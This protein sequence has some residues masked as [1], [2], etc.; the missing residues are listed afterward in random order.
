MSNLLTRRRDALEALA[1]HNLALAHL[2]ATINEPDTLKLASAMESMEF[3]ALDLAACLHELLLLQRNV[4]TLNQ[5]ISDETGIDLSPAAIARDQ[6]LRSLFDTVLETKGKPGEQAARE[7]FA[8]F[9]KREY[10]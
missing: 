4:R 7:I 2:M 9:V 10:P 5:R 6:R 3:T 1:A 8:A